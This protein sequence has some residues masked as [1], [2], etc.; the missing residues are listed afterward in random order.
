M[1]F[2]YYQRQGY[3]F[4]QS[5]FFNLLSVQAFLVFSAR[6]VIQCTA[7]NVRQSIEIEQ[8]VDGKKNLF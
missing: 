2:D 3:N 6:T 5:S 4:N 8:N 7:V 1:N